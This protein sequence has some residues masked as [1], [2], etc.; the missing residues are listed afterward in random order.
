MKQTIRIEIKAFEMNY[1]DDVKTKWEWNVD[2]ARMSPCGA[3]WQ[4]KSQRNQILGIFL[5]LVEYLIHSTT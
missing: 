5:P 3:I 4:T 1:R 2:S